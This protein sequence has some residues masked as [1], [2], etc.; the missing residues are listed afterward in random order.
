[1]SHFAEID[2]N[3]IVKRV[4]VADQDFINSGLV[5]DP[6]NW[7]ETSYIGE[8]RKNYA[9]I[10]YKYDKQRDAFIPPKRHPSWIF[11]ETI[12]Q[13]KAPVELPED[14]RNI[15]WDEENIK[16]INRSEINKN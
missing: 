1:M 9:G 5:G 2:E 6:K 16:W 3:S 12:C 10:G 11:D 13:F 7:I 14:K 15:E 8:I 4:I